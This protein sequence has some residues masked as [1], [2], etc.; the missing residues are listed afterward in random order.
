MIKEIPEW[1]SSF[2]LSVATKDDDWIFD[3]RHDNVENLKFNDSHKMG[4][5]VG[6]HIIVKNN[7]YKIINV[8][9]YTD[10]TGKSIDNKYSLQIVLIVEE[11]K[12]KRMK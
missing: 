1:L 3:S 2:T 5:Y 7:D 8:H 10:M 11:L 9:F 4:G 6:S 12:S